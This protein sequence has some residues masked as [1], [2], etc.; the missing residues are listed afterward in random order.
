M[1]D[2][3]CHILPDIDDG[4]R[5]WEI[6]EEMAKMAIADGITHIIATPHANAQYQYDRKRFSELLKQ[7]Q[8]RV[9]GKLTFSLGCDFH[10]SFENLN[11]LFAAPAQFLI[12]DTKYLLIELNDY[13]IPPNYLQLLFRMRSELGITPVL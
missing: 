13:S 9:G 7:L 11:A 10:I 5:S 8:E 2:I 4:S 1:V 12:G 6:S 3:H